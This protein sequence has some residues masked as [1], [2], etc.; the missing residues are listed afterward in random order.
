LLD[1]VAGIVGDRQTG[2]HCEIQRR[3]SRL[4][5]NADKSLLWLSEWSEQSRAI[6]AG[7][8]MYQGMERMPSFAVPGRVWTS[9]VA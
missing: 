2:G 1:I 7:R 5:L 6:S 3:R 8:I 4:R 9:T